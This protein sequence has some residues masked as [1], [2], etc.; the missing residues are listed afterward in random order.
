[1]NYIRFLY[2]VF[3]NLIKKRY[4]ISPIV[5]DLNGDGVGTTSMVDGVYFDHDG[6][7]FAEKTAWAS[8]ADGFLAWDRNTNGLIDGGSELFGVN[9]ILSDGRKA[10]NGF[11]ALAEFNSNGDGLVGQGE[12]LTMSEA[13]VAGLYVAY[14]NLNQTDENGNEHRQTGSFIRADGSTGEMT[15]VWFKSNPADTQFMDEIE[16]GDDIKGLPNLRGYGNI[17]SLHQA[18]AMDDS[19]RLRSLVEQFLAA[20]PREA[21]EM[22]WDI[23]YAWTGVT[24]V[25][26][27]SRG[28][29]S[30]GK[31]GGPTGSGH[32]G[33]R[34]PG[35]SGR[36]VDRRTARGLDSGLERL[37]AAPSLTPWLYH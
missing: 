15:D 29:L 24:E 25:D 26:S 21:E 3:A 10:A 4:N 28:Q 13:G 27:G 9:Y 30:G 23:L 19:G 1:M 11:E 2:Q 36:S 12:M 18:M 37:L 33:H 7:R 20:A 8:P 6:N 16:V 31:P 14:E 17:P 32:G 22:T 5:L 35:W 34:G